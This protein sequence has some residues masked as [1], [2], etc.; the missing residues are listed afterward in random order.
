LFFLVR[1]GFFKNTKKPAGLVAG[2][3]GNFS[4]WM[5]V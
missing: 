3:L 5:A 2:G 4:I 1:F